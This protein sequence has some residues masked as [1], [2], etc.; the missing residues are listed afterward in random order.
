MRFEIYWRTLSLHINCSSLLRPWW[1]GSESPLDTYDIAHLSVPGEP[2]PDE[3]LVILRS[4]VQRDEEGFVEEL[5]VGDLVTDVDNTVVL[6]ALVP[7]GERMALSL[8][9][10][11][12]ALTYP[13]S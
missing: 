7:V 6:I 9:V 5:V 13:T 10:T 12:T 4:G 3:P 1:T 8:I 11:G 2:V